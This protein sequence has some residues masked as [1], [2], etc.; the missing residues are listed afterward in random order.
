MTNSSSCQGQKRNQFQ[1]AFQ[2]VLLMGLSVLKV[3][4][5]TP[6]FGGQKTIIGAE[7]EL[8]RVNSPFS[9]PIVLSNSDFVYLLRIQ[10]AIR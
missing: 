7:N 2:L 9:G 6:V 10:F 3:P 4:V 5:V 1:I 8:S